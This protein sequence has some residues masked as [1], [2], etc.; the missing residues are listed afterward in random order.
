[1]Q[2]INIS[3]YAVHHATCTNNKTTLSSILLHST[4]IVWIVLRILNRRSNYICYHFFFFAQYYSLQYSTCK[5]QCISHAIAFDRF[6]FLNEDILKRKGSISGRLH[7]HMQL[8][9]LSEPSSIISHQL[10]AFYFQGRR[11]PQA[12]CSA[13]CSYYGTRTY[14]FPPRTL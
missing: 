8:Y 10:I 5:L 14:C 3:F 6:S 11:V 9:R 13:W 1:M 2:L 12:F 4:M 7:N